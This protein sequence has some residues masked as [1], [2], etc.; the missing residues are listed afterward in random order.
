MFIIIHLHNAQFKQGKNYSDNILYPKDGIFLHSEGLIS[1]SYE[2]LNN[3]ETSETQES[4][5]QRV[6]VLLREEVSLS[7]TQFTS[8]VLCENNNFFYYRN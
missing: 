2:C 7:H 4:V 3:F 6:N 8:T 1:Y 5:I